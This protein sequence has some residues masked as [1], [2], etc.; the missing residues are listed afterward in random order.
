MDALK[1]F[2]DEKFAGER[3]RGADAGGRAVAA[4]PAAEAKDAP[5]A[6]LRHLERHAGRTLKTPAA[7][8]AYLESLRSAPADPAP[9]KRSLLRET[10]LVL[11]LVIAI[12]QYYYIDVSLQIAALNKV[13]TFVPVQE[14]PE[15]PR[16]K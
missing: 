5:E 8:D 1:L 10:A 9:P 3:R 12:L 2:Y 15:Q 14:A 13:T 7:I 11:F 6:L 4:P 16:G